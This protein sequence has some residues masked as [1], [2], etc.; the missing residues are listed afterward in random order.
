MFQ[1]YNKQ[2]IVS[3][4]V[5][6][7]TFFGNTFSYAQTSTKQQNV[8]GLQDGC[9]IQPTN[10]VVHD[11]A[12]RSSWQGLKGQLTFYMANDLGRNGYYDQKPIAELMGEMAS[13]VNPKC[14][15]AVGDIHHFNG[16][17]SVN[18]PLWM[19]NYELIYSHPDLM[20]DWFPVCGNHEYRGNTQAVLDYA[21]ISRRWMMP[22]KYYTRVYEKKNTTVRIVFLDTT[23]L[24]DKYRENSDV[25][26]D[27][28]KQDIDTQLAWLDETLKNAKE[29]WVIVVGHHPI[30]AY[31]EKT[32]N[33][34]LD[35]QK[36]VL[37]IL[38][39]YHNVAIYACG[40]IHS[41]QH[42]K[43]K[44]DDIDYIVNSSASLA[45]PVEAVEGTVFCSSADGFS[46]ITADKKQLRLSMIDHDGNIIHEVKKTK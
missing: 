36:R 33:E 44:G 35:M 20:I 16:V 28:V 30:Y 42:L 11:Y 29:D 5:F 15:L 38:Q 39:R 17:A 31:T 10:L 3:A 6:A 34:R 40:H 45:R 14:V 1:K 4:V 23:P 41:F 25:Y 2:T 13:T 46:V 26:P 27:A 32:E 24:I 12:S 8:G 9:R 37:P 22:A 18:D 7:F 43:M 19:T 21:K